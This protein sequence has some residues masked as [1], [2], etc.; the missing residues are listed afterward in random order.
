MSIYDKMT[1]AVEYIKGRIN[2]EPQVGAVLGSGLGDFADTLEDKILIPYHE[3]PH[4]KKVSVKGHAGRLVVGTIQGKA[5]AIL[6]GRYHFYEGHPIADVVFPIRV[7]AHLGVKKVILTNAAGGINPMLNA[8]DLM[9]IWDHIN[10]M[11]KNPLM[12]ENEDRLGTRFPDM[13]QAYNRELC[14]IARNVAREQGIILSVPAW[15]SISAFR[16]AMASSGHTM[17][18]G[19]P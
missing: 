10:M 9:I 16:A 3:I 6:Q 4:F 13:S 19:M 7:L 5:A 8:G 1:E 15:A 17:P 14:E 18:F 11:G 2:L 12:G